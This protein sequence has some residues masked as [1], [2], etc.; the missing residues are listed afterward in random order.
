MMNYSVTTRG[1]V[2]TRYNAEA[3]KKKITREA[4][5]KGSKSLRDGKKR[6]G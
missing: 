5:G 2:V 1:P 3:G 6:K 4:E